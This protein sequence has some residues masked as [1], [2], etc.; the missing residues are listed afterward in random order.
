MKEYL[1]IGEIAKLPG[2]S[3][4]TTTENIIKNY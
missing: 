4:Q 3:T 1:F 2:V